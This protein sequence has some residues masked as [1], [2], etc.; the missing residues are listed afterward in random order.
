MPETKNLSPAEKWEQLTFA[1]DFIF[2]K[3]LEKNLDFTKELLE[4][5]LNIQIERVEL[6]S[7]QKDCK[8]NYLSKGARFDVYVKDG[9]GRCFDIEI[10]TSHFS[11]LSKRARYYQAVMDVDSLQ[12]GENYSNLKD[13]YVIFLCL[14]DPIGTGLPVYT[15]HHRADEDFDFLMKDGTTTVFFNAKQY[16]KMETLERRSFF[17][18]LCKQKTDSACHSA[19]TDKLSTLVERVKTSPQERKNYMMFEE[20]VRKRAKEE[21]EEA[22]EEGEQKKALETAK[23]MLINNISLEMVAKCTGLPLEQVLALQKEICVTLC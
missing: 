19:F 9:T 20:I 15:F 16:D 14:G 22:L 7:A 8:S 10:Q 21:R 23:N 3:V 13:S 12:P 17:E 11:D 18:Y 1:D 5:L 2:C 4:L 6:S